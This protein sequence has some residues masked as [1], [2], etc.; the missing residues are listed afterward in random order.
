MAI[1]SSAIESI[2]YDGQDLR[3]VFQDGREHIY[4][5]VPASVVEQLEDSMSAGA[6]FN[7]Y[8]R[9]EYNSRRVN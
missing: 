1:S 9:P 2:D 6:F 5:N 7:A 3:V 4:F 8:I